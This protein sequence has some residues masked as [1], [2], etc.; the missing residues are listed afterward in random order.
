M[1]WE[2]EPYRLVPEYPMV[3]QGMR[4]PLD[5]P[6][7]DALEFFEALEWDLRH[8]YDPTHHVVTMLANDMP[9]RLQVGIVMMRRD[10]TT[11]T[12]YAKCVDLALRNAGMP[13][14]AI[15]KCRDAMVARVNDTLP[16]VPA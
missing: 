2:V 3:G 12:D 9:D 6:Y 10:A 11:N 4:L 7:R 5:E 8:D 15:L 16:K 13:T 14:S 1:N